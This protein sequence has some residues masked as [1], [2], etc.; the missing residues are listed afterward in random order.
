MSAQGLGLVRSFPG[1][2]WFTLGA[3]MCNPVTPFETAVSATFS[4]ITPMSTFSSFTNSPPRSLSVR[5]GSDYGSP[6]SDSSLSSFDFST[7]SSP[8]DTSNVS[9]MLQQLGLLPHLQPPDTGA[10]GRFDENSGM[11]TM[12]FLNMV[13]GETSFEGVEMAGTPLRDDSMPPFDE[14]GLWDLSGSRW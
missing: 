10:A 14:Q 5:S 11:G 8:S 4:P 9:A 12:E 13:Q 6:G 1:L 3:E 2:I 7:T